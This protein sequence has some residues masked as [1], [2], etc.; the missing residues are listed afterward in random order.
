M[1]K[2]VAIGCIFPGLSFSPQAQAQAQIMGS[3]KC[4]KTMTSVAV[5]KDGE[6]MSWI[7][8][9]VTNKEA[10]TETIIYTINED[11]LILK[12]HFPNGYKWGNDIRE[13]SNINFNAI[14]D[15]GVQAIAFTEKEKY[16]EY[17]VF[18]MKKSLKITYIGNKSNYLDVVEGKA[19]YKGQCK[20]R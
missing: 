16:G 13:V 10:E 11:K 2:H 9:W 17:Q 4:T 18:I 1:I 15:G 19:I 14:L 7:P 6:W 3:L 12:S 8:P 5:E 20:K